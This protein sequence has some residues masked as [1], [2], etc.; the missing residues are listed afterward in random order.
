MTNEQKAQMYNK[1]LFDYHQLGNKINAL[2][3]ENMDP[4]VNVLNEISMMERQQKQIMAQL[5]RLM[6]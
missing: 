6:M 2:K 4:S 5:Q 1:M 3:A